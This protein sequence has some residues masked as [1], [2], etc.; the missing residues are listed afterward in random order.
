[1][2]I[3]SLATLL[4]VTASAA[5]A[6]A[7]QTKAPA[8]PAKVAAPAGYKKD[9]PSALAKKAKVAESAAAASALAKVPGGKIQGVELEE[10]GGNLIYSY[11]IAVAGKKG[12]EEVAVDAISGA[13]LKTEHEDPATEK[14]EAQEEAKAAAKTSA[15]K[16]DS[17]ATKKKP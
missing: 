9:I 10:E 6:Q 12:I 17:T 4:I 2:R 13:V 14:K 16:P 7:A 5:A 11:D 1:M 8:A 15:K 3:R